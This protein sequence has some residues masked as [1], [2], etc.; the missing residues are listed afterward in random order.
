[1]AGLLGAFVTPE[2]ALS[3]ATAKAVAKVVAPANQRLLIKAISVDFDGVSVSA[4]PALVEW[5]FISTAGTFT[6][7][8]PA[9]YN[10]AYTETLQATGGHTATVQPSFS[11]YISRKECHVQAGFT[12]VF[13]RELE[14]VVPG[15][16]SFAVN[17]TSP[18]SVNAVCTILYEE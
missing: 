8:T 10:P 12:L 17:V 5:G 7:L 16:S 18:S 13:P 4:E 9:K 6:S 1:M 3:A 14:I 2:V 11:S 15:G